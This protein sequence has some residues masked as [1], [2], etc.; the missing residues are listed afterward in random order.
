MTGTWVAGK[1][2]G[3]AD[4]EALLRLQMALGASVLHKALFE[5][6]LLCSIATDA[7]GLILI[8][9]AGAEH[10]LGYT[11]ASIVH[12]RR[13]TEII[14]PQTSDVR[15]VNQ[16]HEPPRLPFA[17]GFEAFVSGA[18]HGS[19]KPCTLT[20]VH[21]E[22]NHI[23]VAV[24]ITELRD[25]QN[26]IVG[27]LW[28]SNAIPERPAIA[29]ADPP[30]RHI[31]ENSVVSRLMRGITTRRRTAQAL[32]ESEEHFRFL[33]DI[34]EAT[35][36]L[37]DPEQVMAVMSRKLGEQLH[38]S[39]C[40]YAEVMNDGEQFTIL[41][42]YTDGCA[43][44]VGSYQLSLFGGKAVIGLSA[45]LTLIIRDVDA[46]LSPDNGAD[47]FN[48][49]GIKAIITCPLV[50]SGNLRAMMA[51]HQTRPRNWTPLEVTLVQEVVERCWATIERGTAEKKLRD[52]EALL[53]MAGRTARL[54]G[55]AVDLQDA[56]VTWSDQVC[57]ILDLSPGSRQQAEHLFNFCVPQSR[58]R[59]QEA[60]DT[61]ARQ[62]TPFD[63]E[64]EMITANGRRV[65]ARCTGEAQRG[66]TEVVTKVHGALQDITERKDSE[67]A[68]ERL[69]VILESTTDLVSISDPAG[70]ILYLNRAGRHAL[71]VGL[72]EDLTQTLI[73]NFLPPLPQRAD[74]HGRVSVA[75]RDGVWS[76]EATLRS[77]LGR[78][79][80]VSQVVLAHTASDGTLE[81]LST[82]MRDISERHQAQ[83]E[84]LRLN[85]QLEERVLQRTAQL[86]AANRELEAFSYSVS[87]DLR[88]PLSSIDG[89]S[90]LLG[91]SIDEDADKERTRHYLTR[92]RAGV[93]Q[94]GELI[95]A[96]LSLAQLSRTG[97]QWNSVNLSAMAAR[98]ASGYRERAPERQA[99]FDIQP[100]LQAQGDERLLLQVLDN[101]LGNAWKFSARQPQTLISFGGQTQEAGETVFWVRDNGAGFDMAYSEKLFGAF[102][103]L[104]T[105]NDFS[106]TGIGLAT[107]HRIVTRHGGRIWA[108]SAPHQ[109]A[110]FYFTLA[111][112]PA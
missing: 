89:F 91:K 8:F 45:G 49:I 105:A 44:T 106:G 16:S 7:Q 108:E 10:M 39:R 23:A 87:H 27:Y 65:W 58:L 50:K 56:R 81:F 54:G 57:V 76:G 60:F 26:N 11:A 67:A 71:G 29:S 79:I 66:G 110:T 75:I 40:A 90:S 84:I 62:G 93:V 83:K 86:Q 73:T 18:L 92:I 68:R 102:Q 36:L 78:E 111:Q 17:A 109:G 20:F 28:I 19:G 14:D 32:R 41:H 5:N 51:V 94:M 95:D 2:S 31:E 112:P 107:V 30:A 52:S 61:C 59:A 72:Q 22:G 38:A 13:L 3:A 35:R 88:T 4:N 37:D 98:L 9:G 69:A 24:S 6:P 21:K 74:A 48:A 104:H 99:H 82:I 101:L 25:T 100:D 77:R 1:E 12:Q 55:W 42:D 97:M 96:L 46:E 43:S 63:L 33:N 103:R 53:H 85:A 15:M 70:H 34:N 80:P 64:L 47:M